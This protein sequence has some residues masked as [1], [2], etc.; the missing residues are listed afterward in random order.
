MPASTSG[1]NAIVLLKGDFSANG[2]YYY[3]NEPASCTVTKV[4]IES[5]TCQSLH[6]YELQVISEGI[7]VAL[8]KAASQSSTYNDD[9]RFSA[10]KGVDGDAAT[11]FSSNP[12]V[13]EWFE[14]DLSDAFSVDSL[15]FLN[16]GCATN[17]ECLCRLTGANVFLYDGA[18]NKVSAM[19]LGDTCASTDII[20]PISQCPLFNKTK[21][22]RGV[23]EIHSNE[24]SNSYSLY[25]MST[26]EISAGADFKINATYNY[27][28]LTNGVSASSSVIDIRL[29]DNDENPALPEILFEPFL[30]KDITFACPLNCTENGICVFPGV[31]ICRDGWS[32]AKCNIPTCNTLNFCSKNGVCRQ[33]DFLHVSLSLDL[34][35]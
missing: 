3:S 2:D 15:R 34:I 26:A 30:T 35:S 16:R 18:G 14:V 33:V 32:G 22:S 9:S 28:T 17:P 19:Q 21:E 20:E 6:L 12:G 8:N 13:G 10:D 27:F 7:N 1:S 29:F 24:F 5:T 31:C 23:Y 4:K 25:E 11:F